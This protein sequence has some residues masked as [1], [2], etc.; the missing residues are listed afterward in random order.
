MHFKSAPTHVAIYFK[1][2]L[3]PVEFFKQSFIGFDSFTT[4]SASASEKAASLDSFSAGDPEIDLV[5]KK[6]TK[7][8]PVTR[9]KGLIELKHLIESKGKDA[10][11]KAVPFF[12]HQYVRLFFDPVQKVRSLCADV[13][14]SLFCKAPRAFLNRSHEFIG[15]LWVLMSDPILEVSQFSEAAFFKL[16]PEK[17]KL[18]VLIQHADN[19]AQYISSLLDYQSSRLVE[20]RLTSKEDADEVCTFCSIRFCVLQRFSSTFF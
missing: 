6:L 15:C 18:D 2:F 11:R 19:I 9:V 8:D 13:V 7:K 14:G 5:L 16:F 20:L 4:A 17:A 1:F 3:N 10:L 12:I